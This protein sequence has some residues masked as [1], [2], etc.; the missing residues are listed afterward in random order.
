[1]SR[2]DST[3]CATRERACAHRARTP[4]TREQAKSD[5]ESAS[6]IPAKNRIRRM[7]MRRELGERENFFIAKVCDSESAKWA[8][9]TIGES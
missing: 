7:T 5:R 2:Q 8:F 4:T 3:L 9:N 6:A 1:M